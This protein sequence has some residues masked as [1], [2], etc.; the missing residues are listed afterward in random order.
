MIFDLLLAMKLPL[1]KAAAE[2]IYTAVMTDTSSFRL[3]TTTADIF[4]MTATLVDAG[5][6]PWPISRAV[7]ES[8][9]I[10]GM[11]LMTACLNTLRLADGGRSAWIYISSEMYQEA[12]ADVED[13][14]GLIDYARSIDGVEVA[15]FIRC[16]EHDRDSWKLS[17]RGKTVVDVGKLAASLGGGGH[18]YAAGCL[19]HGSFDAVRAKVE[20]AVSRALDGCDYGQARG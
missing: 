15:V 6:E 2:G 11:K 1:S 8:R 20:V 4:R 14:E 18:V 7:Y 16:D 17:F 3:A 9:S 12:G 10:C 13:T 5:V 19:L